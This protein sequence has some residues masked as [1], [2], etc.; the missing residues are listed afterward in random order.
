MKFLPREDKFFAYFQDQVRLFRKSADLLVDAVQTGGDKM[1]AAAAEIKQI[2]LEGDKVLI[3]TF[4]RLDQTF[5]TPFDPEDIYEL[6]QHLDDTLD[7]IEDAMHRI[8]A[9]RVEPVPEPVI[10]FA[11]LIRACSEAMQ[12]AF[13]ALAQNASITEPC[14]T[15]HDLEDE[16]DGVDRSAVEDLLNNEKDAILVLKLREIYHY[17]EETMDACEH[18]ASVVEHVYVKNS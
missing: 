4:N 6:S 10:R 9:Y 2:E 7:G 15:I 14:K 18:V 1:K 5:I 11:Q 17:L 16:A 12:R 13:E 8:V 3:E